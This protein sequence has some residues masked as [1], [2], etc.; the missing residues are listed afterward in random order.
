MTIIAIPKGR[1]MPL[2]LGK[3]TKLGILKEEKYK[4][5]QLSYDLGNN[6]TLF[7]VR[8]SDILT[9]IKNN[10]ADVAFIGS[11][12]L[13][14]DS[15]NSGNYY[16]YADAKLSYCRLMVAGRASAKNYSVANKLRVATKYT[17]VAADY[18]ARKG[19]Q[20]EI[21]KINGSVE[22]AASAGFVDQIVDI[23]DTGKTLRENN[24]ITLDKI[25]D[26]STRIITNKGIM[27]S[28]WD[29]LNPLLSQL[30]Q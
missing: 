11:D 27:K 16:D 13:L 3:L 5:R 1:L 26:V 4:E 2:C 22:L 24:L 18:Y 20:A 9:Y 7:M 29:Q 6:I 21:I 15:D 8:N 14:E 12:L 10:M 23:V 19:I 30:A 17:R 28:K 25:A